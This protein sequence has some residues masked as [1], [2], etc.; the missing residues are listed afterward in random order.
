MITTA[1]AASAATLPSDREIV[2]TRAF[3]APRDLVWRAWT[4][5]EHFA[6]WMGPNGFAT[7]VR[8]MDVREGGTSRYTMRGPDGTDYPN[9]VRYREVVRPERLVYDH[10]DDGAGEHAFQVTVTLEAEG[11][12]TRVTMRMLLPTAEARDRTVGFGAVE[13]G[14]QTLERLAGHLSAM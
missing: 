1:S 4:E 10:D 5:P 2:L 12:G 9:R 11:D 7:T 13:L 14:Y 8:E 3:A 6:R